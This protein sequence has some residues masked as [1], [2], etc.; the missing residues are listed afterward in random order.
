MFQDIDPY[1]FKNQFDPKP[2]TQDDYIILYKNGQVMLREKDGQS[3]IP[4][5]GEAAGLFS[6]QLGKPQ[7]LFSIDDTSFFLLMTETESL[8]P[9]YTFQGDNVFRTMEPSWLAFA[10]ATALHLT[11]WYASHQYC[12]KC[13]S[14][15][16]HD[17][18]ER[19][20]CCPHCGHKEYPRISPVVIVGITNGE[21]LLLTKYAG[22]DYKRYAL[23]AGFMEIG[24][25][26]EDTIRR[27]VMEEVG[28]NVK[29]IRYYN[30]Q[31]WAFSESI[32]AGFFADVDGSTTITLDE[33]ELS[34]AE[35]VLR[36][37]LPQD[38]SSLSLTGTMME[39][40][41]IGEIS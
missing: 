8:P 15:M 14:E 6:I 31:P 21:E 19:A 36:D 28:L 22:R 1:N 29:N 3:H 11:R 32:L 2:I 27:E 13:A 38:S 26:F 7:Y 23:V 40:F 35:W 30:S 34:H 9:G 16:I 41:R 4:T 24:E 18:K 10:G 33:E 39:S 20:V 12:G 5:Y 25:T 37:D 17:T